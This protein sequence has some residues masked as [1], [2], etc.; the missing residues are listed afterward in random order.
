MAETAPI[1]LTIQWNG[2]PYEVNL[3]SASSTVGDVK[4]QLQDLTNVLIG[5]QKIMGLMLKGKPAPDT[6][7]ETVHRPFSASAEYSALAHIFLIQHWKFKYLYAVRV[8]NII[9]EHGNFVD[10]LSFSSYVSKQS[11]RML[12]L[13]FISLM[14]TTEFTSLLYRPHLENSD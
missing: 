8:G 7:R 13:I 6:V 5:R 11:G 10:L 2:K 14:I 1:K 3:E 4:L 12:K 9:T